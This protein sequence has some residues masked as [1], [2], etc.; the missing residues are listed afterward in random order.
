MT[1]KHI[2]QFAYH[3]GIESFRRYTHLFN[4]TPD[5]SSLVVMDA[6]LRWTRQELFNQGASQVSSLFF[7]TLTQMAFRCGWA[8][9]ENAE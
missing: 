9:A 2:W 6:D 3:S 1:Y 7:D 8:D 4:L 5:T